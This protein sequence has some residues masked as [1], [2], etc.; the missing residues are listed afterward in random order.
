LKNGQSDEDQA[1]EL[2]AEPQANL[3]NSKDSTNLLYSGW[4]CFEGS[5]KGLC[6]NTDDFRVQ[7]VYRKEAK[8]RK[9]CI[10]Y[11]Q[12]YEDIKNFQLY[13]FY[14]AVLITILL[15]TY[16]YLIRRVQA[17]GISIIIAL[18]VDNL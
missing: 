16:Q 5:G 10:L 6:I 4:K 18:S 7:D 12:L 9:D 13:C 14:T 15:Q 3:E 1:T 17:R 11:G 2:K 8:E